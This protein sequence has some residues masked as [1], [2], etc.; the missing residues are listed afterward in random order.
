[1]IQVRVFR[2]GVADKGEIE[3]SKVKEC[4]ADASAF[5]WFDAADPSAD[6]ISDEF[7]IEASDLTDQGLELM[8]KA[9]DKWVRKIDKGMDPKDTSLLAKALKG[10]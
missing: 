9:Y 6:D 3:A 1:M 2:G 7:S 8:R 5:V 10:K 4:L